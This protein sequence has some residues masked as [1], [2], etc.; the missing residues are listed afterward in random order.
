MLRGRWFRN[1]GETRTKTLI[2][3]LGNPILSDDA[4]GL[5]VARRVHELLGDPKA[6]LV[7]AAVAGLKTV[8]LLSHY[9]RGVIIDSICDGTEVGQV[10]RLREDELGG[11]CA[12]LSHGVNLRL[13]LELA[14][15]LSL[16]L[17]QELLIYVVAVKDPYT[18]GEQFTPEVERALPAAAGRIAGELAAVSGPSA[19]GKRSA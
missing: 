19:D 15:Q 16:P 4:T 13:A 7:E 10:R 12:W 3:G 17:P 1:C 8:Q 6:D 11:S 2:L 18:F 14:R 5:S 9:D